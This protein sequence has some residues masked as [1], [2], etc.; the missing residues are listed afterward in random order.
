MVY[1]VGVAAVFQFG[2]GCVQISHLA[3]I[4]EISRR[5][6]ERVDLNATRSAMTFICG[7][8]T[9]G[10]T[11]ILLGQS[12]ESKITPKVWK[13][14][15]YLSFIIVVSGNLFNVIFHMVIKEP[16]SP[17]YLERLA[18]KQQNNVTAGP[19]FAAAV[20]Y[21]CARLV[22]NVSQSYLPLYLTETLNFRKEA[23]A[24][25]P[26][27]ALIGGVLTTFLVRILSKKLGQKITY[28]IGGTISVGACVWFYL[29]S[30]D[31]RNAVY[32]GIV[33]M[34][35]GGSVMLVTS[36]S[37]I[38]DLV[39]DDKKCGAFVYG[40]ISFSD[41]L[42]SGVVIAIIQELS[43]LEHQGEAC[44]QC[45]EYVRHVQSIAPGLAAAIGLLTV[46]FFYADSRFICKIKGKYI[47]CTIVNFSFG[48]WKWN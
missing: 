48:N 44:L 5:K 43:P 12:T 28:I 29:Q 37:M 14:F 18:K 38:A 35:S 10:V 33:L 36:L 27:V 13:E 3:L 6:N 2:W 1:Y 39:G 42:S 34:G 4:P 32:A 17:A 19:A 15:M 26:L 31:M 30:V 11:W 20:A 41:K 24:Y 45:S 23:I 46:I 22:V 8:Y 9:Y 47:N 21:M 40:V 16:L 7:I 25:F